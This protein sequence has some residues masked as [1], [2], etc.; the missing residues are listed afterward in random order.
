MQ[1]VSCGQ[2]LQDEDRRAA[3]S[4][5]IMGDEQTDAFFLCRVCG[6]YTVATW[7]DNFTGEETESLSFRSR[8]G[9]DK[10]VE[11]ILRCAEP[12]NK[13]CRCPVHLEYFDGALD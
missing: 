1:C 3:I 12:W 5:S 7:W 8:E 11:L 9:G 4:G 10:S 6:F 2:P 13:K